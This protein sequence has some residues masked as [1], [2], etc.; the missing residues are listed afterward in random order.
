MPLYTPPSTQGFATWP[1][2]ASTEY[3][4]SSFAYSNSNTATTLNLLNLW[5]VPIS[6]TMTA[7]RIG[8]NIGTT[9]S[10]GAVVRLG[11]YGS[12]SEYRPGSLVLDAGTLA[13]DAT[14][15]NKEITISQS[16]TAGLY[17]LALVSQVATCFV[18][19]SVPV[20]S[21]MTTAVN[22][23]TAPSVQLRGQTGVT[24]ALP[25]TVTVS[26]YTSAGNNS[27]PMVFLRRA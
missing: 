19:H 27:I 21:N 24:G 11:I 2:P 10:A 25:G 15:G 5:P 14:T 6:A 3:F 9:G 20:F 17:W 26:G 1:T 12:T 23:L 8:C 18:R 13:A 4:G 22:D 16:L 7:D